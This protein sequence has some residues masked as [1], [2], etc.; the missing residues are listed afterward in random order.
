MIE[1]IYRRVC[2]ELYKLFGIDYF[3]G[4]RIT[5]RHDLVYLGTDYG[6][7]V[8][9][10][11]LFKDGEGIC[12][13]AGC[14]EDIS[15]D[16]DLI[17]KYGCMVYGF[18]P[19]PRAIRY[20]KRV[21]HSNPNYHLSDFGLWCCDD[22]LFFY[23]PKNPKHVSYSALNLQ[24]TRAFVQFR[25]KRLRR[26]MEANRHK[27][28]RLLKLDI[29]G[30]EYVVLRSLIDDDLHV[31]VICVEYDEYLMPLDKFA[32]R[33]VQDSVKHLMMYGYDMVHAKN[34]NYTFVRKDIMAKFPE[35]A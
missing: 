16:I 24:K 12:Y 8:I 18:D 30:A 28:L 15:F 34:G 20:V 17:G 22:E 9:P 21:M 29:E 26:I 7:K 3:T 2:T 35:K 14:G 19:T 23:A 4:A 31:T 11:D 27:A 32:R 10:E 25:V 33:R 5:K 13:C 6:G 1:R